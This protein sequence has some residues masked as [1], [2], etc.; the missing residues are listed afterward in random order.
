MMSIKEAAEAV[1]ISPSTIRYYDEQGLLPF[2]QRDELGYRRF[3]Q[4]DL[5]WL[6]IIS[7]MR[8]TGMQIRTLKHIAELHMQGKE[9]VQERIQIFEEH[10]SKL[11]QQKEE[12]DDG[13][14]KIAHK[15][16]QLEQLL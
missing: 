7:C 16:Q 11:L 2:V 6:E 3:E 1:S 12:I 5:F 10:R 15:M 8:K 13:L 9:T 14:S 4:S